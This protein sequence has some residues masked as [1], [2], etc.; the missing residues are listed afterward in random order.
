ME[1]RVV[2]IDHV[3]LAMPPGGEAEAEAFYQGMLGIP[4]VE[5]PEA[6]RGR[7]GCWFVAGDVALHLGVEPGFRPAAKA[8]PGLVVVGYDDL[9]ARLVAHGWAVMPAEELDGVRRSHV[10][11]PF[12][13]RVELIERPVPLEN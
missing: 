4:R 7:Q 9:V 5:K 1:P 12:G 13:N 6:L 11:D 3:Q 2:G 10:L 8:H